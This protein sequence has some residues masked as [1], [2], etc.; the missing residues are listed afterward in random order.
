MKKKIVDK[1]NE[2][3]AVENPSTYIK[4][5]LNNKSVKK[6]TENRKDLYL[7]L[8]LSPKIFKDSDV[9]DLGAGAGQNTIAISQMGAKCTLIEYDKAS[10]LKSNKLFKKFS[11]NKYTIINKDIFKFKSKKKFDIVVN[12][13]VSHHTQNSSQ[14]LNIACSLVKKNGFIVY[15]VATETGMFQRNLMRYIL[16]K[17]TKNEKEIIEKSKILFKE[18]LNRSVK[19]SGRT[20]EEVIADTFINPKFAPVKVKTIF[21]IFK[22]HKISNYST[23]PLIK[24]IAQ[25]IATEETQLKLTNNKKQFNQKNDVKDALFLHDFQSMSLSDNKFSQKENLRD[26]ELIDN[27]R[28]KVCSLINDKNRDNLDVNLQDYEKLMNKYLLKISKVK[29]INI[30]DKKHE[31]EFFI[32]IIKLLNILK[33]KTNN[34]IIYNKLKRFLPKTKKLF[35]GYNGVGMNYYV[36]YKI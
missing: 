22:K 25:F 20:I 32:E 5:F 35:K 12:N 16:F 18:S 9:L 30:L 21:K 6:F 17:I 3:Y 23:Y 26:L 27:I 1:V 36:G 29:T 11:K 31:K 34:E 15:G 28:E 24:N 7:E 8:K 2:V 10:C 14:V 4:T 13:G 19:F 33:L